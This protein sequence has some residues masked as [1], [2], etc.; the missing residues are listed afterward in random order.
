MPQP[1]V[2]EHLCSVGPQGLPSPASDFTPSQGRVQ[3]V[4]VSYACRETHAEFS[5]QG[6]TRPGSFCSSESPS[7]VRMGRQTWVSTPASNLC[8]LI[9]SLR[10]PC[11]LWG[12]KGMYSTPIVCS[13]NPQ[14]VSSCKLLTFSYILRRWVTS[15]SQTS[16]G[17]RLA[18]HTQFGSLSR[19]WHTWDM[20][21]SASGHQLRPEEALFNSWLL[22]PLQQ[23]IC[24]AP[25]R[26]EFKCRSKL[27]C[28]RVGEA[29]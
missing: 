3:Q 9:A 27:S 18:L 17:P 2:P 7:R 15:E 4:L 21:F 28:S 13:I 16:F 29:L 19:M 11:L 25:Q 10:D 24:A 14:S 26:S 6:S 22:S 12:G 1:L 5:P 20:F 23:N 8:S